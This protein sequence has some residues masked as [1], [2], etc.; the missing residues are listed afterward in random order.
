MGRR[1][2]RG[3]EGAA[4]A[5]ERPCRSTATFEL[6]GVSRQSTRR[7]E[8]SDGVRVQWILLLRLQA[9]ATPGFASRIHERAHS[10]KHDLELNVVL[11]LEGV[12]FPGE[13]DLTSSELY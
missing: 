5:C 3:I 1:R 12:E 7:P 4:T 10:I 9:N 2:W 11:F 6:G 13:L 8:G